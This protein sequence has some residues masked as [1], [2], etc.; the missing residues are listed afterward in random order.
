MVVG[1][2]DNNLYVYKEKTTSGFEIHQILNDSSDDV[3]T[4]DIT[5]DAQFLLS[6]FCEREALIYHYSG[7]TDAFE[8]F[9]TII[10]SNNSFDYSSAGAIT[11]DHQWIIAG[12][13][14][15]IKIFTFNESLNEF[16]FNHTL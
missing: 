16:T 10:L 12:V 8:V 13:N 1:N 14:N 3:R 7:I 15:T 5:G 4:V 2:N 9:Q 11:D 6:I